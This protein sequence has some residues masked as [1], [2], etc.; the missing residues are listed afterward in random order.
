M[1]NATRP[2]LIVISSLGPCL[3]LPQDVYLPITVISRTCTITSETNIQVC[4]R[5]EDP[6]GARQ[7][8]DLDPLIDIEH[9]EELFEIMNHL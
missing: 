8:N 4:A 1:A 9:G 5:T 3:K 2:P 7:D 6:A